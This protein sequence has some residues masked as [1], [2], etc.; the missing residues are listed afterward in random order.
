[1]PEKRKDAKGRV[2]KDGETYRSDG[3][4][5][6]RY[7]DIHGNRQYIYAKDLTSLRE[8]EKQIQQDRID[9]IDYSAGEITVKELCERFVM[10]K[11]NVRKG[12]LKNYN[13]II[14]IICRYDISCKKIKSVKQSDVKL[15]LIELSQEY[16]YTSV[17]VCKNILKSIFEIA[18]KEDILRKNPLQF[19]LNDLINNNT[20]GRRALS[21][22][23]KER[24]LTGL[25]SDRFG[26]EIYDEIIILLKTGLRVSELY[27]L[28]KDDVDCVNHTIDINKQLIYDSNNGYYIEKPKSKSGERIIPLLDND[29]ILAFRNALENRRQATK[30]AI[31][32]GYSDFIFIC[33]SGSP[34]TS[35]NLEASLRNFKRRY[36]SSHT[37]PLPNITPHILRHTFCTDMINSGMDIKSLQ[38]LMGHS[39]ADVTMNVYAHSS[40]ETAA[41]AYKKAIGAMGPSDTKIDTNR[42]ESYEDL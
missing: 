13:R 6:Y 12:T 9:G 28:T 8:K 1:M 33:K 15:F 34:K 20:I 38:Y 26:K 3:R 16:S 41:A 11:V 23:E 27:G 2:L 14:K 32:D 10:Q 31:V 40:Y 24:F 36:D 21:K 5:M 25:K 39:N 7:T 22:E 19:R 30:N 17:S 37:K 18:V 35:Q 29:V 42:D 4:Y